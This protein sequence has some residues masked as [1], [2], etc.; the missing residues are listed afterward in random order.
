[1]IEQEN[2]LE[3]E[4]V[5]TEQVQEEQDST[6]VIEASPEE[7][8]S[9]QDA[10][11]EQQKSDNDRNFVELREKSKRLEKERD[12]AL[13]FIKQI[14]V[15]YQQQQLQTQQQVQQPPVEE[16]TYND[17]DLVEGKHLKNQRKQFDK[18][19]VTIKEELKEHRRVSTE[20]MIDSQIRNEYPDF[21]KV[22]TEENIKTLREMD[23]HL[24][25][26]LHSNPDMMSKAVSTY[27]QI[28]QLGIVQT[29]NY[30]AQKA[31]AHSNSS[32]PRSTASLSPQEGDS[33]LSRANAFAN[34]LTPD[35]KKQLY[36]EMKEKAK[37]Y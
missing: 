26:S 19:L 8:S 7:T 17:D 12:E 20:R 13:N 18:E 37:G 24:A 5:E 6:E 25:Y 27:R 28:K 30:Q 4:V 35:L 32:K 2:L 1:M 36:K 11:E 21:Y 10:P 3:N 23:P 15:A 33:P 16:I 29:D 14:E 31:K 34:G 9:E 22:V